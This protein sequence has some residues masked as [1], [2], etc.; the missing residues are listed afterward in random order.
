MNS[1]EQAM[2]FLDSAPLGFDK[3]ILNI[4]FMAGIDGFPQEATAIFAGIPQSPKRFLAIAV[5]RVVALMAAK[6]FDQAKAR[7]WEAMESDQISKEDLEILTAFKGIL[8]LLLAKK[9]ECQE[10][11]TPLLQSLNDTLKDLATSCLDPHNLTM[12]KE[13][14]SV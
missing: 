9:D 10:A 4:G 12:K 8:A 14:P 1:K 13:V 11:M 7:L 3:M 6:S 2:D 5:G